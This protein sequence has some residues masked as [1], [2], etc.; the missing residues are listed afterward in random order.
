MPDSNNAP[1]DLPP[2]I[3]QSVRSI[4]R[5]HADHR[6]SATPRERAVERITPMPGGAKS[7]V[8]LGVAVAV[9]VGANLLADG[10]G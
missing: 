8:A 5:L 3:E 7:I 9:W 1:N 4:A 2:H 10:F 6:R